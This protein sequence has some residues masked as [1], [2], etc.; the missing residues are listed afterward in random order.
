[1]ESSF[2]EASVTLCSQM[3]SAGSLF[4]AASL[5]FLVY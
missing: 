1:M 3:I 2:I 4:I 5:V